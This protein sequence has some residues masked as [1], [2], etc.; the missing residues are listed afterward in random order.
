MS[1]LPHPSELQVDQALLHI[2]AYDEDTREFACR[3]T[4]LTSFYIACRLPSL[5][6]AILVPEYYQPIPIVGN[7]FLIKRPA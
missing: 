6:V 4:T 7:T 1:K 5:I 2:V 3:L